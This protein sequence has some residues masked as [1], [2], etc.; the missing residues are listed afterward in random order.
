MRENSQRKGRHC[1]YP[2]IS[3]TYTFGE[4]GSSQ[5]Q[6]WRSYLQFIKLNDEYV[7]FSKLDL[8][9]LSSVLFSHFY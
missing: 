3:R 2:E 9:Y 6:F 5:G 8:S 4:I 7:D 1:I